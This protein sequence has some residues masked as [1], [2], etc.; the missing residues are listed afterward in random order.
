MAKNK[1][2]RWTYDKIK[3][4]TPKQIKQLP[5]YEKRRAV[6][7]AYHS[8]NKRIESLKKIE[9]EGY[10]VEAIR[11]KK[12]YINK[13]KSSSQL[14]T[15]NKIE[16]ELLRMNQFLVNP[17]S[18]K[19]GVDKSTNKRVQQ[20]RDIL[21]DSGYDPGLV[22]K[23]SSKALSNIWK[24]FRLY[25][26]LNPSWYNIEKLGQITLAYK[27]GAFKSVD[28][29]DNDSIASHVKK[30]LDPTRLDYEMK[31]QEIYERYSTGTKF[32][33]LTKEWG[34]FIDGLS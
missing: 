13:F 33:T 15:K 7:F 19:E 3:S 6:D 2:I 11:G 5:D 21:S 14:N 31:L 22:N 34:D 25:K 9:Q 29:T 12:G 10:D 17:T 28:W 30:I 32:T 26:E 27:L 8:L 4:L 16:L 18:S 20:T 24:V 23:M 1:K